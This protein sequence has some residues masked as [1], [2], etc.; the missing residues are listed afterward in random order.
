MPP[1]PSPAGPT[2]IRSS[3]SSSGS[4][5][6]GWTLE[7]NAKRVKKVGQTENVMMD[8]NFYRV[9]HPI[10]REISSCFVLGVPLP[11]LGSS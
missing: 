4:G 3:R 10:V 2:P 8:P 7:L 5:T 6:P 9:S 11:C 1:S